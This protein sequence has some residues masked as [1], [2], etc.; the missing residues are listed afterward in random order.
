V[1]TR[2]LL[3]IIEEFRIDLTIDA[4]LFQYVHQLLDNYTQATILKSSNLRNG[5]G[6]DTRWIDNFPHNGGNNILRHLI[7]QYK[8]GSLNLPSPITSDKAAKCETVQ[9]IIDL[10]K[11]NYE[12]AN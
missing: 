5:L 3:E 9:D 11:H 12:E 10:I 6:I 1:F 4:I 2:K 7:K 8:P